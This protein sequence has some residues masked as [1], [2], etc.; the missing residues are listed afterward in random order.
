[1]VRGHSFSDRVKVTLPL[2]MTQTLVT[3]CKEEARTED[4]GWPRLLVERKIGTLQTPDIWLATYHCPGFWGI[5]ITEN[6]AGKAR[7]EA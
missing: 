3:R 1:M 6:I 2:A 5:H 7:V 4:Q